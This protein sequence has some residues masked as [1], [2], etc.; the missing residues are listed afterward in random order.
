[1]AAVTP[2][3]GARMAAGAPLD[4]RSEPAASQKTPK[5]RRPPGSP[6]RPE[7]PPGGLDGRAPGTR[8]RRRIRRGQR[9][10]SRLRGL[11]RLRPAD[12]RR[13]DDIHEP[14]LDH[15]PGRPAPASD[16]RRDRR[17]PVRRRRQP[18][19]GCP[20][21]SACDPPGPV[22]VRF[23]QLAPARGRA[24][25]GPRR[26]RR[27]RRERRA[28]LDRAGPRD[29]LPQGPRGGRDRRHPDHPRW[30]PLDHLAVGHRDRRG[31]PAR[32]RSG[33]STSTPTPTRP[34]TTGACWPATARRCAG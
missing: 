18:P 27:R 6:D 28:G 16:G 5:S 30:R 23:D 15:R 9:L 29:D 19:V 24:V 20:L 26:G 3:A 31:P 34:T 7:A 8:P 22:H 32:H 10:G 33:S 17:R 1:M 21:R 4:G 12:L 11:S 14:A 2:R 25:R 13:P